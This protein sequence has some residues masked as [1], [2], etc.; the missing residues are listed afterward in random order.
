MLEEITI[1][2][3]GV[4]SR[5]HLSL[6]SGLTAI[7]GETG[8]GKTMLLTGLSLLMGGKADQTRVRA[9]AE[10][11]AVEGRIGIAAASPA[12]ERI[13]DAGG[14]I[15]D[16][17]TLV[18][19]RTVAAQGRSRAHLGGRSVP[20]GL[21]AQVASEFVTVHG[22]SEQLRLRAPQRQ[23]MALDEYLG[24]KPARVL[25][26]YRTA[27]A[28]KQAVV[29]EIADLTA[30]RADREREL[31]LLRMGLAEVER[32]DPQPGEDVE[33]DAQ[34]NRLANVEDLRLAA[35]STH[36]AISGD[37]F[38]PEQAPSAVSQIEAARRELDLAG[39]SDPA[40]AALA[41]R[42]A[43][44]GYLL[45]DIGAD[46]A[47]YLESLSVDP[48]RLDAAHARRAELA[49]LT[50]SYGANIDAVLEWASD[51]GL[52]A[53]DLDGGD[54]RLAELANQSIELDATLVKLAGKLTAAREKGATSLAAAVTGELEGLAMAGSEF[55]VDVEPAAD[56]LGPWGADLIVMRLIPHPGAPAS[57]LGQGASGGELSRVMLAIEVAL[58][59]SA[60]SAPGDV[61]PTF[62]FDEVDAGVG[63]RAALEVGRRLAELART[64]Q[65]IVVTHLAQVAAFADHHISVSKSS[66]IAGDVVTQSDVRLV[67]GEDRVAELAR[68]LSGQE[69]SAAARQH[70]AELLAGAVVG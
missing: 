20:Q 27:W 45:A 61:V 57:P 26:D 36:A 54:E 70:A 9:G 51:A 65:V 47:G 66:D 5:T 38:D 67:T 29:E 68:M 60:P 22:Q 3:L 44:V 19:L 18:I 32:I 55:I 41:T 40:L 12:R 63:G 10:Q 62:V 33:L 39:P 8:A 23:R 49:G 28:T 11:A 50:R 31:E 43:E 46:V 69:D 15:D 25:A 53:L 1:E 58:A 59:Q 4:I 52:R 42:V 16:D 17:D 14:M 56:G 30:R 7:T 21:L 48:Q 37:E 2:N 64:A 24:P 6:S 35:S 13:A 34:I